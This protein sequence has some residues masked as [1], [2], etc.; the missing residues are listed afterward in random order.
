MNKKRM[1]KRGKKFVAVALAFAMMVP[2]VFGQTVLTKAEEAETVPAQSKLLALKTSA[3]S[4]SMERGDVFT[5]SLMPTKAF[6]VLDG[7]GLTGKFNFQSPEKDPGT[8]KPIDLNAN[9][10]IVKV[11]APEGW[12]TGYRGDEGVIAI[13]NSGAQDVATSKAIADIQVEVLKTTNDV[14]VTLESI[15][16]GA[17]ETTGSGTSDASEKNSYITAAVTN[18]NKGK[19]EVQLSVPETVKVNVS[20]QYDS[21]NVY[22]PVTIEKNTGFN[23]IAVTFTYESQKLNY[24]GYK[25]S[26]RA[27]TYLN[28]KTEDNSTAGLVSI[29]FVGNDDTKFTGDFLTLEFQPRTTSDGT[30]QITPAIKELRDVSGVADLKSSLT[31]KNK[32]SVQFVEG[33]KLGDVN[34][35]GSIN[36]LDATYVLQAYNGVRKLTETQ[37]KLADVNSDKKVNLVDV[38]KIM[39]YCNGEIKNF[40]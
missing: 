28:Y 15:K 19:H 6:T 37:E 32:I 23:A 2:V 1:M 35:D 4:V 13:S 11:S 25:L 18:V 9:F 8:G 40:N 31:T 10:R 39:K 5:L 34:Q 12:A 26:P 20:S 14:N 27:L 16:L 36:L 30:A 29:C 3:T 38:L 24:V 17:Q 21:D 22:I 7:A 33:K